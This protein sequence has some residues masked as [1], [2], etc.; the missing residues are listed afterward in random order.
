M[1]L[2][3]LADMLTLGKEMTKIFW[4]DSYGIGNEV[5]DKQHRELIE[6][7]N[8]AHDHLR[9]DQDTGPIGI[10]ALIRMV[11][12][13]RYHFGFEE[14]YMEKIG[15]SDIQRHKEIHKRFYTTLNHNIQQL[16]QGEPVKTSKILELAEN[17]IV[18]HILN[19]DKQ[20]TTSL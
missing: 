7:F 15:F 19:E 13:C 17:W 20:I 10:N 14:E 2:S 5:I 16:D 8:A 1:F 9:T 18:H 4:D 6:F 3:H 11:E 12:Y